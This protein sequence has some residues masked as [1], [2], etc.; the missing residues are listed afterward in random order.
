[1]NF[2][3][4]IGSSTAETIKGDG[5]N[6]TI[7]LSSVGSDTIHGYGG[8]DMGFAG[9]IHQPTFIKYAWLNS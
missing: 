7:S 1:M 6:S 4:I 5:D 9:R 3:N 8:D 2:E